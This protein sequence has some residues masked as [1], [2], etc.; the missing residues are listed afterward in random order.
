MVRVYGL[1]K[2]Y[3]PVKVHMPGGNRLKVNIKSDLLSSAGKEIA[4]TLHINGT[5][6]Y[7][8]NNTQIVIGSCPE[9]TIRIIDPS[10][11]SLHAVLIAEEGKIRIEHLYSSG[12]TAIADMPS[13][14]VRVFSSPDETLSLANDSKIALALSGNRG[15][16]IMDLR[17]RKP[18]D[19]ALKASLMLELLPKPPIEQLS[20]SQTLARVEEQTALTGSTTLDPKLVEGTVYSKVKTIEEAMDFYIQKEV[21]WGDWKRIRNGIIGGTIGGIV[22]SAFSIGL[23]FS[24]LYSNDYGFL[25]LLFLIP[26]IPTGALV[27]QIFTNDHKKSRLQ[28]P[29]AKILSRLPSEEIATKL[30]AMPE[31]SR[32]EIISILEGEKYYL[33]KSEILRIL[34]GREKTS[35][36]ESTSLPPQ[37]EVRALPPSNGDPI[38]KVLDT[39]E[40]RVREA[41]SASKTDQER[42]I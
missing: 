9:S 35:R 14:E 28:E 6:V 10:I 18:S 1:V 8:P 38:L 7:I 19:E 30:A 5:P 27:A 20:P 36:D 16:L 33:V 11:G 41:V 4:A 12:K 22:S 3:T 37:E 13:K 17:I 31:E 42:N 29:L 21:W 23:G 32:W 34:A 26:S 24:Q 25:A 2:G 39:A 15:H 40:L